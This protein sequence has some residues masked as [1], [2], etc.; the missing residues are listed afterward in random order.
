MQATYLP[1]SGMIPMG[2]IET[3]KFISALEDIARDRHYTPPTSGI[4]SMFGKP[5][6]ERYFWYRIESFVYQHHGVTDR[7]Y[8]LAIRKALDK[9]PVSERQQLWDDLQ[10]GGTEKD[11]QALIDILY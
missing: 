10:W 4:F 2:E 6:E 3:D 9:A 1:S 11:V 8:R 5:A 7:T